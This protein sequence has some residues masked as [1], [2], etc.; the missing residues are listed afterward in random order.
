M[1][2]ETVNPVGWFEIPAED[3][4]RAKVFYETVLEKSLVVDKMGETELAFFP[5]NKGVSGAAGALVKGAGYK[6]SHEGT[7]VYFVVESIEDT[8]ARITAEGGSVLL[9]KTPIGEHGFI[10]HFEDIEGNRVA[11][12]S[13]R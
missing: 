11:L 2:E 3:L 13:M 5:M 12:H 7:L 6:P 10:A 8:L 4:T 1:T 9:K